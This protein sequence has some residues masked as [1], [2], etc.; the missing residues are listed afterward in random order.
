MGQLV[1]VSSQVEPQLFRWFSSILNES[2]KPLAEPVAHHEA[3]HRRAT[4]VAQVC[5]WL[6][7]IDEDPSSDKARIAKHQWSA[8]AFDDHTKRSTR[9]GVEP[10]VA[11]Q[12]FRWFSTIL[13][14]AA[15]EAIQAHFQQV[16][17]Q[18][19]GRT[20]EERESRRDSPTY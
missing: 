19:P 20:R 12:L 16:A 10:V 7:R 18:T 3:L 9:A 15:R 11:P 13:S 17:S 1:R 5:Q 14:Q 2:Q 6:C 4:E 8:T